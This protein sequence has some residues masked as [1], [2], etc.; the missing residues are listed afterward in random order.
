MSEEA[1]AC[2]SAPGETARAMAYVEEVQVSSF[3]CLPSDTFG[4]WFRMHLGDVELLT[5]RMA[6][7][8]PSRP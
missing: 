6:E 8:T 3:L 1:P 2:R 5:S 7:T 4:C